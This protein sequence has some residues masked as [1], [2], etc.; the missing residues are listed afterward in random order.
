MG[1]ERI[2]LLDFLEDAAA[3]GLGCDRTLG[4]VNP[5]KDESVGDGS[6]GNE[7]AESFAGFSLSAFS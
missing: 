5:A 1:A 6:S 7:S 3:E 2:L 4:A